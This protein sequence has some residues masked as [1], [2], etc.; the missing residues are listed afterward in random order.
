[1][2]IELWREDARKAIQEITIDNPT[3]AL[4][5][6]SLLNEVD[7]TSLAFLVKKLKASASSEVRSTFECPIYSGRF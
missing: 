2:N 3:L 1:M 5:K 6:M 4:P 7:S